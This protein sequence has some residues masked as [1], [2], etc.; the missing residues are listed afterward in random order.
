MDKQKEVKSFAIY[1]ALIK[2]E[3]PG[4]LH[5][6]FSEKVMHEV[7]KINESSFVFSRAVMQYASV[8]VFAALT[9][10]V[11]NYPDNNVQYTKTHI[12]TDI[13]PTT[14]NVKNIIDECIENKASRKK[15]NESCK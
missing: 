3:F 4:I 10:Y 9:L 12:N 5:K 13:T 11:L 8:F 2:K 1:E 14:E 15:I 7:R 6:N